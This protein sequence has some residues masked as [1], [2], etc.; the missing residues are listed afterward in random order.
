MQELQL[1]GLDR[2]SEAYRVQESLIKAKKEA[3]GELTAQQVEQI[4]LIEQQAIAIDKQA[5]SAKE[6]EKLWDNMAESMQSALADT[7]EDI[8]RNG[9]TSFQE[10]ADL[11]TDIFVRMAAELAAKKLMEAILDPSGFMASLKGLTQTAAQQ[12]AVIPAMAPG[13]GHVVGPRYA[14]RGRHS[15]RVLWRLRDCA[16]R[17]FHGDRGCRQFPGRGRNWRGSQGVRIRPNG[18]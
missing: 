7:F 1:S 8:L 3:G 6:M 18:F 9:V 17:R 5:E 15:K 11:G 13:G 2:E 16:C 12:A 4:K 14:Y 10:L